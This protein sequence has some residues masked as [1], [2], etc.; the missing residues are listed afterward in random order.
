M[1]EIHKRYIV[2][3]LEGEQNIVYIKNE[4]Y[5]KECTMQYDEGYSFKEVK[6]TV[7]PDSNCISCEG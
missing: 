3:N 1:P 2:T 6:I 7:I 5:F 4:A